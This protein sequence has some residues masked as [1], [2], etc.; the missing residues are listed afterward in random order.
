MQKILMQG[1]LA[2]SIMLAAPPAAAQVGFQFGGLL[3]WLLRV[4]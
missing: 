2:A 3:S 4:R 1:A